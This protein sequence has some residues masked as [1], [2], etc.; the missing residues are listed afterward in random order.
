MFFHRNA[1]LFSGRER[2]PGDPKD[3]AMAIASKKVM[4]A[5][6]RFAKKYHFL[7]I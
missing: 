4:V 2:R 3:M 5:D 7:W 1:A 6:G